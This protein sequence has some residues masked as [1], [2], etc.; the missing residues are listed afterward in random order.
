MTGYLAVVYDE[1]ERPYTEYPELLCHYLF[2]SFG[3]KPGMTML[4]PGCGRGEFL[5]SFRKQGLNVQGVDIS[6]EAQLLAKNF[7]VSICNVEKEALPFA[8]NSFDIVYSKSF[9]E[10]L[11]DPSLYFS[12]ANR[13]LKPGGLLLTLVPDWESN[14]KTYFDDFT[15]R[16]PFTKV[17]LEDAY[18]IFG[19]S[20]VKVFKFRQLPIVW[21]YPLLNYVCAAISPFVPVRTKNKFFRWSRELMLVGSARKEK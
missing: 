16:S 3:M 17:A 11:N 20:Q 18:R 13:V 9:I 21:K 4:E 1:G 12:E 15:H 6:K 5:E 7:P 10:H 14:Y 19:F 2:Q 8:D